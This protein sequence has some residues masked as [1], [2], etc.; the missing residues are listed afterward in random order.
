MTG[1]EGFD[2]LND[3]VGNDRLFG[4]R[5]ATTFWMAVKAMTNCLTIVS[6]TS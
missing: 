4:R 1:G 2:T 6:V 5:R 3:G